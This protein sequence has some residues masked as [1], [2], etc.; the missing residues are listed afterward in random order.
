MPAAVPAIPPKPKIAA[1]IAI[2]RN[3][4]A[5]LSMLKPRPRNPAL[6]QVCPYCAFSTGAACGVITYFS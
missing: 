5:Q 1:M 2:T 4:N 6:N 3:V